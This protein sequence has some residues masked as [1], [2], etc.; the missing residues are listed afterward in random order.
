[1]L[2]LP[3][4]N[5]RRIAVIVRK[6]LLV[7]LCNK[8]SRM[9]IIVPP[10]MQIVVFGWAAPMEVRNV[11]VAVLNHDGGNWSR[12]IIRAIQGSPTFRSVTF[13]TGEG[14]IR[15]VIERQKALFVLVFDEQFSRQADAGA[16]AQLQAILDGRRSNAA[17]IAA[18]YLETIIRSISES[19]PMSAPYLSISRPTTG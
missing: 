13:L 12:E 9:L 19:T 3:R 6:E 7:L 4:L 8:V 10:L 14:E 1:M 17:Q 5:P 18:Y 15:P 16:P 11:D 2:A